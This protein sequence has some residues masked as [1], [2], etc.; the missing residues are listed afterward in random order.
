[1]APTYE[2]V[3]QQA[4]LL[5]QLTME[6]FQMKQTLEN[7]NII[8]TPQMK[9]WITERWP[10]A[11]ALAFMKVLQYTAKE[12]KKTFTIKRLQE[13]QENSFKQL[14]EAC[15][16]VKKR[17]VDIKRQRSDWSQKQVNLPSQG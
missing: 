17:W 7:E 6:F 16:S 8:P 2:E 11:L 1:M 12:G 15:D 10:Y 9:Q 3:K 13:I 14:F 5:E 4:E